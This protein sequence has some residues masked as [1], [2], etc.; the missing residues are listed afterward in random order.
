M[1]SDPDDA[2]TTQVR[3]ALAELADAPAPPP[4]PE[5]SAAVIAALRGNH[6]VLPGPGTRRHADRPPPTRHAGAVLGTIAAV[7][8]LVCG[9]FALLGGEPGTDAPDFR[10]TGPTAEHITVERTPP[11]IPLPVPAIHALLIRAPDLGPLSDPAG[12]LT[13][14]DRPADT[15]ILGAQPVPDGVLLVLPG[16]GAA[17]LSVLVVPAECPAAESAILA[18]TVLARP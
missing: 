4:P 1:P 7:A 13:S 15:R 11:A 10:V 8:A 18:S 16:P 2:T 5:V 3:R 6:R 9:V 17:D 12:C 14:I